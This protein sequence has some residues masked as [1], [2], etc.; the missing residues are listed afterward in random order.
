M[1]PKPQ[2]M[3]SEQSP[4]YLS[5]RIVLGTMLNEK[6][7]INEA[8]PLLNE[9]CF[10]IELH[11]DIFK[12]IQ[13]LDERRKSPDVL[14]VRD[15][16]RKKSVDLDI[17]E[18][19]NI[20]GNFA[21][22]GLSDHIAIIINNYAERKAAAFMAFQAER[23]KSEDIE[24]VL[25]DLSKETDQLLQFLS[26]SNES[27][28]IVEPL[29]R[30]LKQMYDRK[31]QYE[32]GKP[33]GI[34]TGLADLNR[35]I[36]GWQ[37]SDLIIIAARPA[38]GKTALA[39]HFAKSAAKAG[40]PVAIFSLEMSSESLADRLLLSEAEVQPEFF[41]HGKLSQNECQ[42]IER[43]CG[44]IDRLP[45]YVDSNASVSMTYIRSK[46]RILHKKGRCEMVVIDYLQLISERKNQ[47]RNREQE[48]A[49]MSREAKILAKDLNIPVLLLSQLNRSVE[50]RSE[51]RP[52]LSDL[53][54]SGAIEQDADLV[55]M[56]HRPEYYDDFKTNSSQEYP[57]NYG[58]LLLLKNRNGTT[59]IIPF[60]HN[61]SLT[62]IFDSYQRGASPPKRPAASSQSKEYNPNDEMPF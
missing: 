50:Q 1:K 51:K 8:L 10:S 44:I 19:M 28:H 26:G 57:D 24:D 40:A 59:G 13:A 46:C 54:E 39:L 14:T 36:G 31:T 61:G 5:E 38:M 55:I 2:I 15:Y 6:T 62:K 21:F 53:R 29:G 48:V 9:D 11:R 7:A 49:A 32:Q 3:K 35:A 23:I 17:S 33:T 20:S 25:I 4:A 58:E 16:L 34:S 43:A 56:I 18:L 45:I 60:Q 37:K 42:D 12:A 27:E 22:T 41:R 30:A 47:G 52:V